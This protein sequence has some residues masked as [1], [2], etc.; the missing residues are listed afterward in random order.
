[1]TSY[2]SRVDYT[3]DGSTTNFAIP[4]P[5]ISEANVYLY[6]NGTVDN[7]TTV[8]WTSSTE[9]QLSPAP[10]AAAAV[11]FRRQ[12]VETS[13]LATIMA[14][15]VKPGDLNLDSTQLLYLAQ[16]LTDEAAVLASQE[17]TNTTNIATL[18]SEVATNT[19]SI[20]ALVAKTVPNGTLLAAQFTNS[21]ANLL[22]ITQKLVTIITG[23]GAVVSPT[24][25]QY[26]SLQDKLCDGFN[27]WD[28][29]RS[30]G[31]RADATS[32]T[33][34]KNLTSDV[35]DAIDSA[36]ETAIAYQAANDFYGRAINIVDVGPGCYGVQDLMVYP[37]TILRFNPNASF[38]AIG[39]IT[40]AIL[41]TREYIGQATSPDGPIYGVRLIR[42]RIDMAGIVGMGI[43]MESLHDSFITDPEVTNVQVSG[44]IT[45]NDLGQKNTGSTGSPV[46][47]N[48]G[49][50]TY[51]P[52]GICIKGIAGSK[53]T[54]N[55]AR[56]QLIRP[57]VDS[58]ISTSS[59]G[60]W[61]GCGLWLGSSNLGGVNNGA[62]NT[63]I[64]GGR[65]QGFAA[66][67]YIDL[68]NDVG[69]ERMQV[70]Y[71]TDGVFVGRTDS[72]SLAYGNSNYRA[73]LRDLYAE[74]CTT[75]AVHISANNFDTE[76]HGFGS[77]A[78]TPNALVWDAH[79]CRTR[80]YEGGSEFDSGPAGA[81]SVS[82][83]T[84]ADF[85]YID[86]HSNSALP[87]ASATAD[88]Y[89]VGRKVF[90]RLHATW[91]SSTFS[92]LTGSDS[93]TI[94]L[95][96]TFPQCISSPSSPKNV[97]SAFISSGI[98]LPS[99]YTDLQAEFGNSLQIILQGGKDTGV[100]P[101]LYSE[102]SGAGGIDICGHYWLGP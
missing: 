61:A 99:G 100:S 102:Q 82:N 73:K 92:G 26:R 87:S 35:Q 2:L 27:T 75:S 95:G 59:P 36:N 74:N 71:N 64:H 84:L 41:N 48:I 34:S 24:V 57:K 63:T 12:T 54:L 22:A 23:L 28:F 31:N 15:S 19:A 76:V 67:V 60:S 39:T 72:S 11:E 58:V 101:V 70:S 81:L 42:P 79:N 97:C 78:G 18:M 50:L 56:N 30:G 21:S 98:E 40:R 13:V 33:A 90:F 68:A 6:Q 17:G 96:S 46:W 89:T 14:G 16:E 51:P 43:L 83:P 47:V 55:A 85:T 8:T 66:A 38:K 53:G 29:F 1:M 3:G 86:Q 25:L 45:Y 80:V 52:I 32:F 4:F 88:F 94:Q 9:V 44:G 49:N 20:A 65:A 69:V 7:T 93:M 10:A 91:G 77:L 5:Y 62:N 37:G